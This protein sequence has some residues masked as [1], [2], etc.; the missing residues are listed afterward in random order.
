MHIP[1]VFPD[2]AWECIFKR[3]R[4]REREDCRSAWVS[5]SLPA[6]SPSA[7]FLPTCLVSLP[8]TPANLSWRFSTSITS[9]WQ[10]P[11]LLSRAVS[12]ISLRLQSAWRHLSA[13]WKRGGEAGIGN[14]VS[15]INVRE[16]PQG[17]RECNLHFPKN[18]WSFHLCSVG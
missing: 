14:W 5:G 17:Q 16:K 1:S 18:L 9:L 7:W 15:N 2:V 6:V 13:W 12:Q 8:P 3:S 4:G 11:E 10:L